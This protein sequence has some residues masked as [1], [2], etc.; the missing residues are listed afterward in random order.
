MN[1]YQ[2]N[3]YTGTTLG[4]FLLMLLSRLLA[5]LKGD[6]SI[7]NYASDELQIATMACIALSSACVGTFL[8]LRHMTM[9][10]NA[11]SHTILIGIVGAYFFTHYFSNSDSHTSIS[12]T[13]FFFAAVLT[14]ILTTLLVEISQRTLKLAP[15]VSTGL[16]FTALFALGVL[17]VT[18]LTRN[19][20]IGTEIVIGNVDALQPSDLTL[21]A[22]TAVANLALIWL[23]YKEYTIT[24]FD[25]GFATAL[26][27]SALFYHYLLMI[28]VSVTTVSGFRA[29]G[30]LMVLAFLTAPP[31]TARL[32]CH[33]LTRVLVTASA[34]GI[35]SA[36]GGVALA[37]HM[38]S[39]Y[40]LALSTAG[41]TVCLLNLIFITVAVAV[42]LKRV[43]TRRLW[44]QSSPSN[45]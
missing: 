34:I 24:T 26:G 3:P 7:E 27:I 14:G 32:L 23:F 44:R 11:L 35:L 10:A 28:Q 12:A 13:A 4:P 15:D 33:T 36:I 22:V 43:M 37:R 8:V 18:L 25:A 20:H 30:V 29:V 2:P 19:A 41:L 31:L 9:L 45:N 42:M 39:S 16:T 5:F 38:L 1:D 21:A 6:L 17:L 40:G